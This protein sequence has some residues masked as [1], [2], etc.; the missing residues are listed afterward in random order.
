MDTGREIALRVIAD[1][2]SG[3]Y[4]VREEFL[5]PEM[6]VAPVAAAAAQL[7]D[8]SGG[9]LPI[10]GTVSL[11]KR[12]GTSTKT[13][14]CGVVRGISGPLHMGTDYTDVHVPSI[15]GPNGYI[16]IL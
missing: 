3:V 11:N 9:I 16:Q 6:K 13:F 10:T 2:R 14:P 7:Y 1:T 4:L 8:V 15:S 5:P 12:I